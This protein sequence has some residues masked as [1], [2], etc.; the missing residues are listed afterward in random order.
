MTPEEHWM[1]RRKGVTRRCSPEQSAYPIVWKLPRLVQM[2]I[3]D[4]QTAGG[5]TF[6]VEPDV[7]DSFVDMQIE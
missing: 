3:L 2:S 4:P 6:F 1:H 5:L 7:A